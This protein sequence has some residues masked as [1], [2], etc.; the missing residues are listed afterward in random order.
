M[1]DSINGRQSV[2]IECLLWTS[3]CSIMRLIAHKG[4]RVRLWIEC[5]LWTSACSMMRLIAHKGYR[6]S[7]LDECLQ[8]HAIHRAQRLSSAVLDRV[9]ALDEPAASFDFS[10]T[11]PSS[12]VLDRVS[13]WTSACSITRFSCRFCPIIMMHVFVLSSIR[14]ASAFACAHVS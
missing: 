8:H 4:Y 12:A 2:W 5:L 14:I 3:A 6:V 13:A 7:A 1:Q 11:R 9:S 10:R